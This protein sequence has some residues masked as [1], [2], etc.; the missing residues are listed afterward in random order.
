MGREAIPRIPRDATEI[1]RAREAGRARLHARIG[2]NY[3][4][5]L[6]LGAT[7]SVGMAA[8]AFA[9]AN[10]HHP[11]LLELLTIPITFLVAN[12]SEWRAHK[13]L[14]HRR[15]RPLHELYDRHTPEH[16][17]VFGYDDMAIRD[18]KE[19]KL[20]LIPA[21]G[22]I[23]IVAMTMPFALLTGKLFGAN[24]GWLMLMTSALYVAGYEVSHLSYHLP[25]ESFVGR[26]WLVRVL[27]EQHRRHHHPRLMQRWNF[28]VTFPIFDFVHRTIVPRDVLE[29][30]LEEDRAEAHAEAPAAAE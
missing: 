12:A 29:Q 28:N 3:S 16:H 7:L 8:L 23:G 9:L 30:T 27:R 25:P 4:P 13:D 24:C 5:W 1:V 21:I 2:K 17:M 15:V 11:S 6:H 10:V 18:V 22:V 14:L 26:L 19:L 20:V